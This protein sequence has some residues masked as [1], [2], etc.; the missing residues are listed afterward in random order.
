MGIISKLYIKQLVCRYDKEVGVPYYSYVD[1]DGLKQEAYSFNNSKGV[2]I[3]YY[4]Y[5]YS[6]H[7]EDKIILFCHG[8]GPGHT[9]YLAEIEALCKRGFKVLTLDY[10]GCGESGGKYLGSLNAPTRDVMELL[11]YLSLEIP[12]VLVGHSLGGFTALNVINLR[13]NLQKAVILSGFLSIPSLASSIIKNHFVVSRILKYEEKVEPN[14]YRLNN[15]EYLKNTTDNL[16]FIQSEDDAMVPYPISLQVVEGID[17]PHIK[18]LRMNG[19]KHNPNYSQE[20]VDYMNEVFS[21]YNYLLKKKQI[22]TDAQKIDYFKN[23]SIAKLT[24][25]DEDVI[26]RIVEYINQ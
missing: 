3:K 7:N 8:I 20:A 12:I 5:Y 16:F 6:K 9:A 25:Q 11:D 2:E 18:T 14:Y 19:R 10:T 1:F 24:K 17:N 22:K 26:N 21:K 23:V 15:L 13:K 4:Y